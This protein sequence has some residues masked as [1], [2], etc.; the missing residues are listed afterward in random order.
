MPVYHVSYDLSNGD[1][2]YKGLWDELKKFDYCHILQS[3]WLVATKESA[4]DL[5]FRLSK[6]ISENKDGV[7]V[8]EVRAN[9]A[10]SLTTPEGVEFLD[11]YA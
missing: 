8:S 9:R 11:R 4:A 10:G 7:L 6:H 1:D 3:T 2:A 5:Y